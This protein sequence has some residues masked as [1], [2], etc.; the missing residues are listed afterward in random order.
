[1]NI[2]ASYTSREIVVTG[3]SSGIGLEITK[4]LLSSEA[5]VIGISRYFDKYQDDVKS[6]P[7]FQHLALD[8]S[9]VNFEDFSLLSSIRKLVTNI[10][11][12][13]FCS[14]HLSVDG[15]D[16][17]SNEQLNYMF[18]VN[19]V[20]ALYVFNNLIPLLAISRLRSSVFISSI[21]TNLAIPELLAYTA[22]KTSLNSAVKSMA[23]IA[24]SKLI[25][26]NA[27]SPAHINT[28]MTRK[29]YDGDNEYNSIVELYPL[30][31]MGEPSDV[32]NLALFLCSEY[33][34][35][36]TGG[37]FMIDGGRSLNGY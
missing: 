30:K 17:I 10:D 9:T 35:W 16:N 13:F 4:R 26:V 7:F 14:G 28:P 2:D 3:A 31:R 34:S 27:I 1:M 21:I 20:S 36:I 25:R 23:R 15:I 18:N 11:S 32:A 24:A 19:Y 37:N 5:H 12:L 29:L 22:S 6:N 33:A 8:L